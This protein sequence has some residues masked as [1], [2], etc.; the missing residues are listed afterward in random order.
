MPT[1]DLAKSHR[2]RINRVTLRSMVYMVTTPTS[3]R[4][5]L[6]QRDDCARIV[7][8]SLRWFHERDYIHGFAWVVMP[9][10]IHW[11]VQLRVGTLENLMCRFKTWTSWQVRKAMNRSIARTWQNG[12]H[13][14]RIRPHEDLARYIGYVVLNPVRAELVAH[15]RDYPYLY[16]ESEILEIAG[17]EPE[18]FT[19]PLG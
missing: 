16:A 9:D 15:P 17:A 2:L 11:V 18:A 7:C 8:D 4:R 6:F 13:E 1:P 14:R 12:F 5:K 3:C 10:H 19:D